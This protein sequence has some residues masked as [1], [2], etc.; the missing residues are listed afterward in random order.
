MSGEREQITGRA[1][2]AVGDLT[3][4][5][6][7]EREGEVEETEGEVKDRVD[8]AKEQVDDAVDSV[9]DKFK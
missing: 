6:E 5:E 4:D 3:G 1:K 2:Q 7:L 8:D 9:A